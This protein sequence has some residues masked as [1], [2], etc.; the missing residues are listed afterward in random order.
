[1]DGLQY[2][3]RGFPRII[4]GR[5]IAPARPVIL[6]VRLYSTQTGDSSQ[7]TIKVVSLDR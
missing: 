5:F 2:H 6:K 7:N 1:M 4:D 3:V